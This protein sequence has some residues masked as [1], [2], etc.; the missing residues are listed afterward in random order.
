MS[1]R[2]IYSRKIIIKYDND[3]KTVRISERVREMKGD[4]TIALRI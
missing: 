3:Q 4:V 1:A 2:H